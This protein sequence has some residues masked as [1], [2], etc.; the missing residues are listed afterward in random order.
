V[1]QPAT[2]L[3]ASQNPLHLNLHHALIGHFHEHQKPDNNFQ[4]RQDTCIMGSV[5]TAKLVIALK[6]ILPGRLLLV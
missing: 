5:F 3:T 6:G 1:E 4:G 2:E